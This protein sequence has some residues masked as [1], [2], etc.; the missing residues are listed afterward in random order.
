MPPAVH[1]SPRRIL[2]IWALLVAA[3]LLTWALGEGR[4]G[5]WLAA[6]LLGIAAFKGAL[7]ALEFMALRRAPRLWPVLVLGW[8]ALVCL[9]IGLAYWKGIAP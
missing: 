9:V 7:V 1:G 6:L 8:L 4:G 5:P 3:T 2:A